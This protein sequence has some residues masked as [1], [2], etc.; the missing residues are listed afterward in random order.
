[1]GA[2]VGLGHATLDYIG[3][4][5][6]LAEWDADAVF[7]SDFAT[8]PGGMVC[9]AMVA[10][11]RLGAETSLIAVVGDDQPGAQV[12]DTLRREGV[13]TDLVRVSP[14]TSTQVTMALVKEQTG[15]RAMMTRKGP[16]VDPQ[17]GEADR[18]RLAAA[19][20]LHVDGDHVEQALE[21]CQIVHAH[22]GIVTMDGTRL[23]PGIEELV[24]NVDYLITNASFPERFTA[25]GDFDQAAR[26]L[27]QVGPTTVVVTLGENGS[28]TWT[29][30]R[31]FHTP[32]FKVEAVD[33]TGAGDVFHGAYVYGLTRGWDIEFIAEFASAVAA[34]KC[35]QLSGQRGIPR[36]PEALAF[37]EERGLK[38]P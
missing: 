10:A 8:C 18:A 23:G 30:K 25:M 22:G 34:I 13:Q 4:V 31:S 5:P 37:L 3:R 1:M 17:L 33:T 29:R 2:I 27:F 11:Q 21:A 6:E 32:A 26:R 38:A 12:I 36:L 24:A 7:M 14:A 9:T 35:R 15:Q 19:Q 20:I 16:N 28:H